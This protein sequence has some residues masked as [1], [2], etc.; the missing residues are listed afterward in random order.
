MRKGAVSKPRREDTMTDT[1]NRPARPL[2]PAVLEH[3]AYTAEHLRKIV[4]GTVTLAAN[5]AR[6]E[7]KAEDV[8]KCRANLR[9]R[10]D[11]LD[12]A[13]EHVELHKAVEA[14]KGENPHGD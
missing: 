3:V 9:E 6:D 7:V 5:F 1:P 14:L 11:A 12:R 10:F 13:L 2:D 8:A 4:A